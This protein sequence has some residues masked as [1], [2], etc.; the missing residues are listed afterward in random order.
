MARIVQALLAVVAGVVT[1][2]L[3]LAYRNP[4][5]VFA[6]KW[7]LVDCFKRPQDY[8]IREPPQNTGTISAENL[9]EVER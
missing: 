3:I 4:D 6:A 2:T 9:V 7:E 8:G 1:A 5:V